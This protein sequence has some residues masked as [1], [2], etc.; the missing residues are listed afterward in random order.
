[1]VERI[2]ESQVRED[3]WSSGCSVIGPPGG[4][5]CLPSA[6]HCS[7]AQPMFPGCGGNSGAAAP[8][9]GQSRWCR[10]LV[11]E[12]DSSCSCSLGARVT[13]LVGGRGGTCA[14]WAS[15]M[16]QGG[17]A[18]LEGLGSS[19]GKNQ[20]QFVFFDLSPQTSSTQTSHGGSSG[21][22]NT[23]NNPPVGRK[24]AAA[25]AEWWRETCQAVSRVLISQRLLDEDPSIIEYGRNVAASHQKPPLSPDTRWIRLSL[26]LYMHERSSSVVPA[27][28]LRSEDTRQHS[29]LV[30]R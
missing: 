20:L 26:T 12:R 3:L 27:S 7:R 4:A 22:P 30:S 5:R 28:P 19:G 23:H 9:G 2:P 16:H 21:A 14:V 17:L 10:P 29:C 18:V 6:A 1:M 11:N 24:A 13:R 8:P 25:G 15:L